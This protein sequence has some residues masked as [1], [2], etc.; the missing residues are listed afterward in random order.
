MPAT[1]ISLPCRAHH[2]CTYHKHWSPAPSSSAP[3]DPLDKNSSTIVNIKAT[4]IQ[5]PTVVKSKRL[6]LFHP[7]I[8]QKA[9]PAPFQRLPTELL[10]SILFYLSPVEQASFALTCRSFALILGPEAWKDAQKNG[11]TSWVHHD[12][13]LDVLQRDLNSEAWWRCNECL[14]YHTR[15]RIFRKPQVKKRLNF[16]D[17]LDFRARLDE[18][19]SLRLGNTKD[20]LYVLDFPLLKSVMSRHFHASQDGI[21]L[22]SLRCRGIRTF[23][24]TE[25]TK[26]ELKYEVLNKIVLDRL[27]LQVTY[28]FTPLRTMFVRNMDVPDV[29]T[30]DFLQA[31]DFW[32]CNHLQA[33]SA[34]IQAVD[35]QADKF[36]A[37]YCK[38]CPT[39]YT[40]NTTISLPSARFQVFEIKTWHNLGAGRS[41]KDIKWIHIARRRKEKKL[42]AWGKQNIAEA[43]ERILCSTTEEFERQLER[44]DGVGSWYDPELQRRAYKT[45]PVNLAGRL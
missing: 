7:E 32:L 35:A 19:K 43:F 17:L 40:V 36:Q 34:I 20:P 9:E 22:N 24:L 15:R 39:Q 44:S 26:M 11:H 13:M 8:Q 2:E 18:K 41:A 45:L 38:Y 25:T 4:S 23:P 30:L 6:S 29:S 28:T 10:L 33:S 5:V 37:L 42:Y 16:Q 31:L 21:C 27:L 14:R 12:Q 1:M 3:T